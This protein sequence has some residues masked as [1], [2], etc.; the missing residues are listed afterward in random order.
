M[1]R[2]L[3]RTSERR[4]VG[5]P[6]NSTFPLPE[7]ETSASVCAVICASPLPR[8]VIFA[9]FAVS[10]LRRAAPEPEISTSIVSAAPSAV[11]LP[12]PLTLNRNWG[13]FI[14]DNERSPLPSSFQSAIAGPEMVTSKLNLRLSILT[15]SRSMGSP[16]T[17]ISALPHGW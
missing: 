3:L 5:W 4:N 2:P 10:A 13:W 8:I 1:T 6:H 14:S 7:I 16:L 15:W 9:D 12:L 11:T 17:T